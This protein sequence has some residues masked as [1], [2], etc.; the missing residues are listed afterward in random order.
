VKPSG[1]T[2]QQIVLFGDD[3]MV[4]AIDVVETAIGPPIILFNIDAHV[5]VVLID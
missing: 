2:Q 4:H 1:E 3:D 5:S